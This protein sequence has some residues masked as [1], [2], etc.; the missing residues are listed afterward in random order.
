VVQVREFCKASI[1]MSATEFKRIMRDLSTIGDTITISAP[2]KAVKFSTMQVLLVVSQKFPFNNRE[3]DNPHAGPFGRQ[4]HLPSRRRQ[5]RAD[6]R[7][8]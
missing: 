6:M 8:G 4:S 1:K 7:A 3:H 2:K 5:Q